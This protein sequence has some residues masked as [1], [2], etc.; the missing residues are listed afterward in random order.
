MGLHTKFDTLELECRRAQQQATSEA[1][2][3]RVAREVYQSLVDYLH[4]EKII[5]QEAFKKW[6]AEVLPLDMAAKGIKF[7]GE[8][9]KQAPSLITPSSVIPPHPLG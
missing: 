1:A 7:M 6:E 4:R 8:K 5:S 9:P 2:R 3:F